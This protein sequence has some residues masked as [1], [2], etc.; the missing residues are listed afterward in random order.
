MSEKALKACADYARLNAEIKRLTKAISDALNPCKGVRGT[1]G[2]AADGMKYGEHD[3]ETHLKSAFTPDTTDDGYYP[4][5][6][7]M[8]DSEIRE[9]LHEHCA[10][11]LRAYELVLE[12]KATKKA[13]G[14]AKRSI[15]AI[16]RAAITKVRSQS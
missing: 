15:G 6:V 2:I 11:C 7:W 16:G 1:C 13:F 8:N 9:Y 14:V 4:T 10:C 3:D 12:R 5:K